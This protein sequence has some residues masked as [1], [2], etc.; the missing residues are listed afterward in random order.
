MCLLGA[1]PLQ[2]KALEMKETELYAPVKQFLERQGYTVKAEVQ[3]CDVVGVRGDEPVV[4]VE[5]KTSLSIKLVLQGV[6]RQ[7]ISD[8]V[9]IACPRGSG[10][11]WLSRLRDIKK[12]CRRLGLGFMSVRMKDGDVRAH[13]DPAPYAPRKNAKRRRGLLAEFQGRKG[14]LNMG[15]QTGVKVMTA[16]RQDTLRMVGYLAEHGVAS[17]KVMKTELSIVKAAS[18]LQKDYNGWFFRVERGVYSLSDAGV[19]AAETFKV[20]IKTFQS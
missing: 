6:D 9:Y 1:I 3:D 13:L 16:Y 4:I 8:F 19:A 17:P 2:L 10:R 18:I 15:G 12:L 20:E 14:D 11:A 5:L 7:A